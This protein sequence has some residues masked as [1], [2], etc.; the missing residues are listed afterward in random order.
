[1]LVAAPF[2]PPLDTT[3][4]PGFRDVERDAEARGGLG[5]GE[6]PSDEVIRDLGQEHDPSRRRDT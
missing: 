4:A 2:D 6:P 5:R 3:T 1:M